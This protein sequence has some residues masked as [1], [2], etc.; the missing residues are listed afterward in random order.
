MVKLDIQP[1]DTGTSLAG[2]PFF[3]SANSDFFN[4]TTVTWTELEDSTAEDWSGFY[5]SVLSGNPGFMHIATGA[6][7]SESRIAT[8]FLNGDISGR[9][10]T[11]F[12]PIPIPAGTRLSA[13]G[14]LSGF[15][16]PNGVQLYGVPAAEA[17]NIAPFGVMDFGPINLD[18]TGNDFTF[19]VV[20]ATPLGTTPRG[21]GPRFRSRG[22]SRP[23]TI[24]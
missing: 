7:S 13:G 6:A 9:I 17:P 4:E 11:T 19:G 2:V 8:V 23:R 10:L 18:V 21:P 24:S 1:F 20:P 15:G 16:Y 22:R 3:S 5:V 14:A 12:V